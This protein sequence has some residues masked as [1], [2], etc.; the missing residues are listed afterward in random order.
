MVVLVAAFAFGGSSSESVQAMSVIYLLSGVIAIITFAVRGGYGITRTHAFL[1]MLLGALALWLIVQMLPIYAVPTPSGD[2]AKAEAGLSVLGVSH[3]LQTISFFPETGLAVLVALALPLAVFA[4]IAGSPRAKSLRTLIWIIPLFGAVSSIL[5]LAQVLGG[6][7]ADLYLY[8]STNLGSTVG[9]FANVNHQACFLVM[10]LPFAI[11]ALATAARRWSYGDLQAAITLL[12][13]GITLTIAAG[14]L[15]AGSVAGYALLVLVLLCCGIEYLRSR[16]SVSQF[17]I[18]ASGVVLA[19]GALAFLFFSSPLVT[20]FGETSFDVANES[21]IGMNI[22][23][24]EIWR[25]NWLLGTG[26]ST[27]E[28]LFP[29]YEN[30]ETVSSTFVNHLHNDYLEWAIEAGMP[31]VLILL[32]FLVWVTWRSTAII[33]VS[34]GRFGVHFAA[35]IAIWVPIFHSLVDY[36]VRNPAIIVFTTVCVALMAFESALEIAPSRRKKRRKRRH[37]T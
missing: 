29:L 25:E 27:L 33:R 14:V 12:Y 9:V 28:Q 8:D 5:G 18:L 13:I 32:C 1:Y 16:P 11:V 36:P 15:M 24:L 34:Q 31:G 2:R 30:S 23:G 20:G 26:P 17:T 19:L 35:V 4:L 7:R 22:T 6:V 10:A 21:R 37:G 3:D